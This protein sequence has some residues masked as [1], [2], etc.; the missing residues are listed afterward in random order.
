MDRGQ[1]HGELGPHY[2]AV[3]HVTEQDRVS[4]KWPRAM[5]TS[6]AAAKSQ[7]RLLVVLYQAAGVLSAAYSDVAVGM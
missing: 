6:L 3:R 5:G 4:L 1:H 2:E 7:V